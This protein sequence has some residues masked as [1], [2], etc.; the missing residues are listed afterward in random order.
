M[1]TT[2]QDA[3][4]L[5]ESEMDAF[6]ALLASDSVPDDCM[7]LEMLD[8]YL[9]GVIVAPTPL[10]PVEWLPS[11]WSESDVDMR[12]AGVQKVL[13]LVL[14]YHDELVETLGDP[15]GWAPFFYGSDEDPD[16]TRLG[17]EWMTGFELGLS[18]WADD[19]ADDLDGHDAATFE[20]LIERAMAPWADGEV[21][22]ADDDTRIEWLTAT[23]AAVRAMRH[24]RDACGLPPVPH[25]T[26]ASG[27]PSLKS[28]D[29]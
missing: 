10:K 24:L 9:A 7:S 8:G 11:V 2:Q 17:D 21:D 20:G 27:A 16:G 13:S 29:A 22:A 1:N 3:V 5:S 23:A 12:G 26:A 28:L 6:E 15:E 19:W 18:L 14:R 4:C 25:A